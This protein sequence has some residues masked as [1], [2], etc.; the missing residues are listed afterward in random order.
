MSVTT[1][2]LASPD[3]VIASVHQS[4]AVLA[5]T[6]QVPTQAPPQADKWLRI[7]GLIRW[8]VVLIGVTAMIGAGAV[9]ALEKF[10]DHG[11][12]GSRG[13]KIAMWAG[14]GGLMAATASGLY[15][16]ISG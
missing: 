15:G 10:T 13:M 12:L 6:I 16:F 1:S 7:P 3:L 8:A 5:D 9:M 2:I 4:A 11:N 14:I